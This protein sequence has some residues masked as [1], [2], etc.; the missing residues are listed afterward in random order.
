MLSQLQTHLKQ[1]TNIKS[2][3]R[4]RKSPQRNKH[5]KK[6]QTEILELENTIP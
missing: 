5:I 3:Q 4:K 2:Q 6:S 1:M